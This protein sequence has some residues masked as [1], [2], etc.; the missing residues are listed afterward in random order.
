VLLRYPSGVRREC[1]SVSAAHLVRKP[2]L[3]QLRALTVPTLNVRKGIHILLY[4]A[5]MCSMGAILQY[6]A[7]ME[8]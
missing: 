7:G 8:V 1:S 5:M 3:W 6:E 4:T 2:A